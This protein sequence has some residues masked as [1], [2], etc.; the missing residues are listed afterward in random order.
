MC[1]GHYIKLNVPF[2]EV[3]LRAIAEG[4]GVVVDGRWK[5]VEL[6]TAALVES[7]QDLLR[8]AEALGPGEREQHLRLRI[9]QGR[10]ADLVAIAD[11]Y[12]HFDL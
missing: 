6:I 1:W 10:V 12:R 9:V 2:S 7:V 3:K 4:R 8:A 11:S 5:I